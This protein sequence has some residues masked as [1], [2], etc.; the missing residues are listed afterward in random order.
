MNLSFDD[1]DPLAFKW[2]CRMVPFEVPLIAWLIHEFALFK[3]RP[4]A[5]FHRESVLREG[6]E[7]GA[8]WA[9][10]DM[11]HKTGSLSV[12]GS[13]PLTADA[14]ADSLNKTLRSLFVPKPARA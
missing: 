2:Y 14:K 8:Q 13:E 11:A 9:V 6:F 3:L 7:R 4:S 12:F 10:L 1:L 5:A